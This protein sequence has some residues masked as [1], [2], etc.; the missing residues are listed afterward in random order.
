MNCISHLSPE[1]S[2][3]YIIEKLHEMNVSIKKRTKWKFYTKNFSIEIRY[4]DNYIVY[5]LM[6][7]KLGMGEDIRDFLSK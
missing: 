2:I 1:D 6:Q 5:F 7:F 4:I 3:T